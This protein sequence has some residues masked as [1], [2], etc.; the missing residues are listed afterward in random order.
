MM[1]SFFGSSYF[2]EKQITLKEL[3]LLQQA[4]KNHLADHYM[5][6]SQAINKL[7]IKIHISTV[8]AYNPPSFKD[9]Q[10]FNLGKLGTIY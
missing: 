10:L 7:D 6:T 2:S 4:F 3:D 5:F 8:P 1:I 9:I